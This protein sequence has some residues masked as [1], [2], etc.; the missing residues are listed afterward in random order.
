MKRPFI[1]LIILFIIVGIVLTLGFQYIWKQITIK[2]VKK[3]FTLDRFA[4]AVIER[5][6]NGAKVLDTSFS[7]SS[8]NKVNYE[9]DKLFDVH[10]TYEYNKEIKTIVLQYGRA[11][12]TWIGPNTTDIIILNDKAEVMYKKKK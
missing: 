12:N 7:D 8:T 4:K 10:V 9:Y 2:Q 11:K 3:Y 1:I 6:L 5:V